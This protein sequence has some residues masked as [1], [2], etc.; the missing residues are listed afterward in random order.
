MESQFTKDQTVYAVTSGHYVKGKVAGITGKKVH[1]RIEVV[2]ELHA[3]SPI[4]V[5][6]AIFPVEEQYCYDNQRSARD[7]AFMVYSEHFRRMER[8]GVFLDKSLIPVWERGA[9][10]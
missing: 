9:Q 1:I 10:A 7:R 3:M 8:L 5:P 6:G 2:A 4:L